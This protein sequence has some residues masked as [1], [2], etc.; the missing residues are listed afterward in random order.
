M[1][2]VAAA[3]FSDVSEKS[4]QF[5]AVEFLK[6][7]GILQGYSDGTFR[8]SKKVTRAEAVKILVSTK[9]SADE[10]ATF[11]KRSYTDVAVDA[12]YR[13]YV[14]AAFQKLGLIHGPPKT[15]TFN[16][17]K[18]VRLGE[19]LKLLFKSQGVDTNAFSEI[20]LPL[21]TD[22]NDATA[23]FYPMMRYAVA[24][25]ILQ[26]DADGKLHPDGEITRGDLADILYRLASYQGG[27]RTQALL[28][29]EES[30]L[31]NVLKM[32]DKKDF[33]QAEMASARALVASRGA[34]LSK[35]TVSIVQAA[36][37]IAESFR[38]LDRAYNAG[39]AGKLDDVLTL[40][41]EAW[42]LA[43]KAMQISP[44]LQELSTRVQTIASNMATQARTLIKQGLSSSS[45]K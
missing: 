20:K 31:V 1:E 24:S 25:S 15:S 38:S 6:A 39:T 5:A 9:M 11:T 4:P 14:E 2:I 45:A 21:A 41:K 27:K 10:I 19:F 30:E 8:P 34:L 36:V 40:T 29:E 22:V 35:P 23:W 42:G 7:R 37:K 12:W 26:I 18:T 13:P 17:E 16:G 32:F 43:D 33:T 3:S 44:S 28:S